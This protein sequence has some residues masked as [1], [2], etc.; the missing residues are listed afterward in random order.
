RGPPFEK[1]AKLAAPRGM[2]Q[3][4]KRLRFNLADALA[5]DGEALTDLFERVLA[6]VADAEP[7]L[8]HFLFARR[9]RLEHRFGLLLQIL[10]DDGFGRR[11][12]LAILDEG[13]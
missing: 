1:R 13:A 9:Q 5:G 10:V 12:D 7:H 3:L 11:D 6:P 8:D 2:A 4:A